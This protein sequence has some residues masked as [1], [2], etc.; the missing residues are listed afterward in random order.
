[1]SARVFTG[2]EKC[3]VC[4]HHI[5]ALDEG[6]LPNPAPGMVPMWFAVCSGC[7]WLFGVQGKDWQAA[8]AAFNRRPLWQRVRN[9]FTEASALIDVLMA[10]INAQANPDYTKREWDVRV[11]IKPQQQSRL[12]LL[13][14]AIQQF[15]CSP[16]ADI[17]TPPKKVVSR[18]WFKR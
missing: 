3:P 16:R 18:G 2:L 10:Q 13:Q 5:A 9:T 12:A 4:D 7:G 14:R 8:Q 15:L 17:Y 1:M 11:M 6:T